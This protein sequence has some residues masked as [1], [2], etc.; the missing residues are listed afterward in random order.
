M[1]NKVQPKVI[2]GAVT[3]GLSSVPIGIVLPWVLRTF[4]D[5]EMPAEV[6]VASGGILASLSAFVGGYIKR[7]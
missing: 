7:N 4:F 1:E 5:V 6:A 2:A 3:G